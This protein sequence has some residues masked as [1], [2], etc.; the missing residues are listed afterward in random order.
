MI[1]F[2]D[3]LVASILRQGVIHFELVSRDDFAL[4]ILLLAYPDNVIPPM[5]GLPDIDTGS[6]SWGTADI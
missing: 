5:P 1:D 4:K 2:A 3:D 6:A